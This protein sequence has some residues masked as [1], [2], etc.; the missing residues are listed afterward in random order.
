MTIHFINAQ[1]SDIMNQDWGSD[2]YQ[3]SE[4]SELSNVQGQGDLTQSSLFDSTY[5]TLQNPGL[6]A[7]ED[8]DLFDWTD[9]NTPTSDFDDSLV[10]DTDTIA[11]GCTSDSSQSRISKRKKK[12]KDICPAD[13][14]SSS[15]SSVK[16]PD[17]RPES[18]LCPLGKTAMCCVGE[19][20][21]WFKWGGF[22]VGGCINCKLYIL[23]KSANLRSLY[24]LFAVL[25]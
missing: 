5:S 20:Q 2:I 13:S 21:G 23:S 4:P 17:C 8:L 11:I 19:K 24:F 15:S 1:A 12:A 25:I 3:W 18:E 10:A 16:Q 9:L 7:P 14:S 6:T 22:S